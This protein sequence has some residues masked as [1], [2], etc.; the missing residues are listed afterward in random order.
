MT[1]PPK[2]RNFRSPRSSGARAR[3]Q[4][5]ATQA[6]DSSEESLD[7]KA[8]PAPEQMDTPS[9]A[10]DKTA[11]P[12]TEGLPHR[13]AGTRRNPGATD[14]AKTAAIGA[15]DSPKQVAA[16]NTIDAIR[17]EGLT[18]RQL[19]MARRVAQKHGIA[20]TSDFDAV[21]QLRDKGINPFERTSAL[22]VISRDDDTSGNELAKVEP[23]KLP[24]TAPAGAVATQPDVDPAARRAAEISKMQ[25]DIVRRR[26]RK[27]SLL[28]TRL[29]FFVGIPTIIAGWY[30]YVIATPMYATKSAFLIQQ[31][32]SQGSSGLGGMFGSSQLAT[33]QDSI[34]VQGYLTSRE[35]M[36]RLDS[37]LGFKSH[38]SQ[39]GV[40][41]ITRLS[42]EAS[43]SEAYKIY[44]KNVKI[45]YDPTEGIIK[46]EV[47]A[48]DPE[49]SQAFSEALITYAEQRI[50][51]LTARLR[52]NQ[53]AGARSSF[54]DAELKRQEALDNLLKVQT[55]V[56]SIDPLSESGAL[57][58]RISQ[59]ETER[60][61]KALELQQLLDNAR[62]N[63]VRVEGLEGDMRRVDAMITN[64]RSQMTE[65]GEGSASLATKNAL[66]RVAEADYTFRDL[67]M[68]Q[69]SQQL[70]TARVEADRQVRYLA[71]SEDP[72]AP[73]EPTYPRAFE[74]TILAFLIFSGIYLMI[75]LTASILR[76][77]VST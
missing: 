32:E 57:M 33:V 71:P 59:L 58:G 7:A 55:Q 54:A 62:P 46:M 25:K 50:D 34:A 70:E 5:E 51:K 28:F 17:N 76:E 11:A 75:S 44:K 40:D 38:F 73:D 35:A 64:L 53:L 15:V 27:M 23:V 37:D 61:L 30:F 29:A 6:Q 16:E 13:Q 10:P 48:T 72:V 77:Q 47:I 19:R 14:A 49:T 2:A 66:L 68:Q 63:R 20:P 9:Q 1:T 65:G 4:A 8:P 22:E 21:R 39:D 3:A 26:R 74:N 42:P 67:M 18:G 36:L 41:P 12:T 24:Q 69:A 31:A 56:E 60:D 52:E 45:G 43:D